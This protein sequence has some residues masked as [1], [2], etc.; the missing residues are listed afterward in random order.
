MIVDIWINCPSETDADRVAGALM[1]RRLIACANRY[2]RIRSQYFWKGKIEYAE[3]VPLLL[4]TRRS[5]FDAVAAAARTVHPYET[6][7]ILCIDVAAAN[8]DYVDWINEV[9]S[10]ADDRDPDP[11]A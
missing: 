10:A 6:P 9:T 3:E 4:K 5:L 2:P 1:A 11:E 8:Q 7:S